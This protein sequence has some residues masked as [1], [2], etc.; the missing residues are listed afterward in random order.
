MF[1]KC[2][3]VVLL[4]CV[5]FLSA[6]AKHIKRDKSKQKDPTVKTVPKAVHRW[7][8]FNGRWYNCD[9]T[10]DI[11]SQGLTKLIQTIHLKTSVT[12]DESLAISHTR[13]TFKSKHSTLPT[14]AP[15]A[16]SSQIQP[17]LLSDEETSQCGNASI[18]YNK[19]ND[20][21]ECQ[22]GKLVKCYR[23]RREFTQMSMPGRSSSLHRSLQTGFLRPFFCGRLQKASGMSHTYAE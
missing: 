19:C 3:C 14:K 2:I 9:K 22:Q 6:H 15:P 12:R 5:V 16:S 21:C 10:R 17:L 23:V 7:I 4:L 20:E 8:K 13:R 1:F 18:V 11:D